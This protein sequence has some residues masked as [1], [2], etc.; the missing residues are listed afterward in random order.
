MKKLVALALTAALTLGLTACGSSNSGSASS[1]APAAE[2]SAEAITEATTESRGKIAVIRNMQNSDHTAQFFQGCIE[3]GEALGYTVDTFMSDQDDVKMQDLMNQAL[4]KDYDIWVLSH[5][6]EG[7]QYDIVS[8]AVEKG[9]KVVGFD[10]GGEHVPGVTYTSQDDVSL[11][12]LSLDAM[13]EQ[14]KT[15]GEEEPIKFAE[16]NV[17]GLIVP[18]DTRHSVIEEYQNEGKLECVQI[19]SPDLAGDTYAQIH[20]AMTA[21]LNNNPGPIG[22]WAATSNFLDGAV[23][24]I[25][26]AGRDNVTITAV[27]IS[28]TELTRMT[29]VPSYYA[30]AAVDPYVIGQVDVRLGV[31][32]T[33]GVET[34][35]TYALD[36]VNIYGKDITADDSMTTLSEKFENFGWTEDFNTDE[37]KALR[38]QYAK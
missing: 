19:I 10:C 13:I 36:A 38:E 17:L 6:N 14:V 32:K 2:S 4:S 26:D 11:S 30:C 1:D 35:E 25:N 22:L 34:P 8:K 15:F 23:D 16:I 12:K 27:D 21:V 18:F 33:L 24:A 3:E 9:I 31:L 28:N 29:K 37:I 5:A 20:T 7:Y